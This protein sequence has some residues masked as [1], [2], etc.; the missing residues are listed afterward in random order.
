MGQWDLSILR[1]DKGMLASDQLLMKG[2]G[3]PGYV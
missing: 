3:D 2:S 1:M